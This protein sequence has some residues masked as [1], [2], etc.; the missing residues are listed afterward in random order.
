MTLAK[1]LT[2]QEIC[3]YPAMQCFSPPHPPCPSSTGHPFP[4]LEKILFYTSGLQPSDAYSLCQY[5]LSSGYNGMCKGSGRGQ[6]WP[7]SWIW[8]TKVVKLLST[9]PLILY[10][11][12]A[13]TA[14]ISCR[15]WDFTLCSK[16]PRHTKHTHAHRCP[17]YSLTKPGRLS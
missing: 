4:L 10:L 6:A 11:S 1:A 8:P 9:Y 12:Y 14:L 7:T 13:Y 17:E 3:V 15:Q 2:L 16:T 5:V